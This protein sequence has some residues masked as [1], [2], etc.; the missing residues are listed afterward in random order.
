MILQDNY[1]LTNERAS[2]LVMQTSCQTAPDHMAV[3]STQAVRI[4]INED[5]AGVAASLKKLINRAPGLQVVGTCPM[6]PR[7]SLSCQPTASQPSGCDR[8]YC[9]AV[10]HSPNIGSKSLLSAAP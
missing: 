4:G 10:I 5:Q 1:N 7:C 2:T 8:A 9:L 6:P 3:R